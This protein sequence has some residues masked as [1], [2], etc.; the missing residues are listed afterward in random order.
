MHDS[1]R[2]LVSRYIREAIDAGVIRALDP[3]ASPMLMRYL[4]WWS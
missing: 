4:P 3:E 2:S 1:S